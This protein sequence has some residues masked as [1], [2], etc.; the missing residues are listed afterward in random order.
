MPKQNRNSNFIRIEVIPKEL[1]VETI[2]DA[3]TF[4]FSYALLSFETQF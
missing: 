1:L 4:R 3:E 2:I